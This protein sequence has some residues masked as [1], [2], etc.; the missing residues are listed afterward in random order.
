MDKAV[1][2]RILMET[3][4]N[5]MKN[6]GT[7]NK[8]KSKLNEMLHPTDETFNIKN[9]KEFGELVTTIGIHFRDVM[10]KRYFDNTTQHKMQEIQYY[11]EEIQKYSS[12]WLHKTPEKNELADFIHTG[13]YLFKKCEEL[14]KHLNNYKQDTNENYN[15]Y[16]SGG[17]VHIDEIMR[18]LFD[19]H[20]VS[21]PAVYKMYN[22]K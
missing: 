13:Q 4:N 6:S 17:K 2:T 9:I 8:K 5:Y 20:N 16:I 7:S 1:K 14:G 15:R 10:Q 22:T 3:F 11:L 21:M 12:D 18:W 19:L